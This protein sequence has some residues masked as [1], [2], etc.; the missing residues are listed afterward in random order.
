MVSVVIPTKNEE[1]LIADIIDASHHLDATVV[2]A[3]LNDLRQQIDRL[4]GR[5]V[6]AECDDLALLRERRAIDE[7]ARRIEARARELD[8]DPDV[9]RQIDRAVLRDRPRP[10]LAQA[11]G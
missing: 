10:R 9:E 8:V 6:L 4:R 5:R 3:W 11:T 1:G 2:T 7:A